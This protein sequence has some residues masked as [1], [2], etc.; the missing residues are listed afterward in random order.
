M[1][2]EAFVDG[3]AGDGRGHLSRMAVKPDSVLD[4]LLLL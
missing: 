3:T 2:I 1:E 4:L